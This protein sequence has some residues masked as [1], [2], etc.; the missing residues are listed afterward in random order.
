M[1]KTDQDCTTAGDSPTDCVGGPIDS[2]L[3]EEVGF[4]DSS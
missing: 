3:A 2:I 1:D 4:L